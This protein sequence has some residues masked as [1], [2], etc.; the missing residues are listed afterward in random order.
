MKASIPLDNL[1]ITPKATQLKSKIPRRCPAKKNHTSNRPQTHGQDQN[2][3][4]KNEQDK[5]QNEVVNTPEKQPEG[6]IQ[7]NETPSCIT[8]V[9]ARTRSF[10][11]LKRS[12]IA[13]KSQRTKNNLAK[14][15][16]SSQVDEAVCNSNQDEEKNKRIDN[17]GDV[18]M[19]EVPDNLE[20]VSADD[21][22]KSMSFEWKTV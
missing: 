1:G 13:K 19:R 3:Q 18:E 21:Q 15:P 20:S 14:N 17:G 8:P 10:S 2:E 11:A 22:V 16:S 4:E 5:Q 6:E 9:A 7:S 12:Y